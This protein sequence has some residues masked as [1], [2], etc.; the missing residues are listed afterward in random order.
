MKRQIFSCPICKKNHTL[1]FA[2]DFAEGRPKYPFSYVYLHQYAGESDDLE[3]KGSTVLTTL[4]IDANCKIR[5]VEA[6][7]QDKDIDILSKQEASA[8]IEQLTDQIL[9]LQ[10]ANQEL[11]KKYDELKKK[12]NE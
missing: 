1:N 10:K 6:V 9:S 4:F 3:L 8:M 7:K 12:V 2:D 11:S 5:G